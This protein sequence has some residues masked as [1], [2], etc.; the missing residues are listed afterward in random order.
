MKKPIILCVDDEKI[1]L[2][3]L[4]KE[5]GST[6]KHMLKVELAESASEALELLDELIKEKYEIPIIISDWLMPEMKGDEFLIKVQSFLPNTRKIM[7]TGQ[8]TTEGIGNAVN[9]AKLYRYIAK[10]WQTEDLE[11][12]V[13][14]AFKSFYQE[15]AIDRQ[16]KEL[17]ELNTNLENKVKL[18]TKELEQKKNEINNLLNKTLKGSINA[19]LNLV[20]KT[21]PIIFQ[22]AIKMRDITKRIVLNLGY[23]SIWE[24]EMASLLSQI[25]C[26]EINE[27]LVNRYFKGDVIMQNEF[28]LFKKHTEKTYNLL[29]QVPHLENVSE[30]I[31]NMFS[32]DKI[33]ETILN[34]LPK[35]AKI[36]RILRVA[37][38]FDQYIIQGKNENEVIDLLKRYKNVYDPI[39]VQSLFEI[40]NHDNSSELQGKIQSLTLS[41]LK[42]GMKLAENLKRLDGKVLLNSSEEITQAALMNFIQVK[43]VSGIIEPIYVYK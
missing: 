42:V 7:L 32:E 34:N 33:D 22:K 31:R 20:S 19:I 8:A 36:S 35:A 10:P 39:V 24:Y 17:K 5:L 4:K 6:F 1:V 25:G 41:E 18:R 28:H 38:D 23:E 26:L 11:L 40:H 12:T 2:D 3:S 16:Q 43:K 27:D 21:N 29:K 15:K 37:N 13:T 30:G 14:Q 9:K